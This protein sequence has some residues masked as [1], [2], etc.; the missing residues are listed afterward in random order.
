MRD[1]VNGNGGGI[2]IDKN[3]N[4]GKHFTTNMMVWASIQDDNLRFGIEQGED[5]HERV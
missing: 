4:V 5:R 3:G 1:L 2:A